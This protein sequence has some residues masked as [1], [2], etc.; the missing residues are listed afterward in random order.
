MRTRLSKVL[1]CLTLGF[2]S[3]TGAYMRPEEIEELM[4]TMNQPVIEMTIP[5]EGDKDDPLKKELRERGIQFD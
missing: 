1:V 5:D 3:L 4:R 2:G